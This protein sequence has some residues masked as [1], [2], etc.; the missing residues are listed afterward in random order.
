MMERDEIEKYLEASL[1]EWEA[2]MERLEE[3]DKAFAENL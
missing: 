1:E 3:I 2:M